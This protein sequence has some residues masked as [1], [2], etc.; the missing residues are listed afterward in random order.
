MTNTADIAMLKIN[1]PVKLLILKTKAPT[2]IDN[3]FMEILR[4]GFIT[5]PL[6]LHK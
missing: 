6:P 4:I 5:Q 1:I 3:I 2:I